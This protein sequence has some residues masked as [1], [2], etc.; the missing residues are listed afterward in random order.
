MSSIHIPGLLRPVIALNGWTFVMELWMYATRI[1][2]YGR[3]KVADDNTT[4]KTQLDAMTPAPVRWKA[5]NYNH[6]FEQPTQFYA[7]ALALA[8]ARHGEDN[9]VDMNLAW[10]YVGTR[11][12][13]SLVHATT[14]NIRVR[15]TV[16]IVSSGILAALTGRAA[17]LAF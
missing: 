12:I 6:L 2:V 16:F 14:N 5:D 7:V 17:L 15:F 3:L 11:L 8:V 13:H 10:A 1:P 4:T 9:A